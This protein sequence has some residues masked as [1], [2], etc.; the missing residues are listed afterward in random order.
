LVDVRPGIGDGIRERSRKDSRE[1]AMASSGWGGVVG[2]TARAALIAVLFVGGLLLW[3]RVRNAPPRDSALVAQFNDRRGTFVE[4]KELI[5]LQ[6]EWVRVAPWGIETTSH[7]LVDKSSDSR[8][9]TAEYERCL[10]LMQRVGGKGAFRSQDAC[11][12]VCIFVWAAGWA[13]DTR[14][15]AVCSRCSEPGRE[16]LVDSLDQAEPVLRAHAGRWVVY[17]P[18]GGEWFLREDW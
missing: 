16:Q 11:P 7:V 12:E 3:C 10:A 17:R 5:S 14:H 2:R 8:W 18:L 9:F 15:I 6:S 13:G 1:S 4:L